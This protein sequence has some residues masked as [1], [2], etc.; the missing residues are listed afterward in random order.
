MPGGPSSQEADG[1]ALSRPGD[2]L[3]SWKAIAAYLGRGITT[4]QRWEQSEGLPV[5]RLPHARGASVFAFK[6]ELDAWKASRAQLMSRPERTTEDL[7]PAL[8]QRRAR[9]GWIGAGL[10]ASA[11]AALVLAGLASW[12]VGGSDEDSSSAVAAP[13]PLANDGGI[14]RSPALSPDGQFVVY[15][16]APAGSTSPGLFI[17]PTAGGEPRRIDLGGLRLPAS[18]RTH[19]SPRGDLIAFLA[20]EAPQ[21]YGLHVMPAM[22]GPP[23][24]ITSMAGIGLCWHPDGRTIG[25]VDRTSVGAPF[26][27]YS[28]D[29]ESGVRRRLTEPAASAFGDTYCALSS[30]GKRLAV[31]RHPTRHASDI[32]V[33]DL[34]A[35]GLVAMSRLTQGMPGMKGIVWS[36]DG[37]WILAGAHGLW[38]IRADG[39]GVRQPVPVA[40]SEGNVWSP[41]VSAGLGGP[42]RLAY[43]FEIFD[44]NIWRWDRGEPGPGTV[45]ELPGSMVWENLAAFSPDGRRIAFASNRTGVNEIWIMEADGSN[46]RQLTSHGPVVVA[47]R[48]SPDGASLVFAAQSADNWEIY[49]IDAD[50]SRSVRLTWEPSQEENPSWSADG[51]W[52]YFRSDRDGPGRIWKMPAGGGPAVRVTSGEGAQALESPDGRTLYFVRADDVPGLWSMPTAGGPETLV[53]PNIRQHMWAVAEGGLAFIARRAI[54]WF[55]VETQ[56]LSVLTELPGGDIQPG[57]SMTRDGR[58]AVWSRTDRLLHDVMIIDDWRP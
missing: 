33:G 27:I 13:R 4:V 44:V 20:Y 40:G 22:G 42:V 32:H 58:T 28:I 25:F 34:P 14:E 23:R 54:N 36:P 55:D 7:P 26:S 6:H 43:A 50:G 41:S 31:V 37:N 53:L 11:A 17:K 5:H 1:T 16:W 9:Q 29:L 18:A 45:R 8:P 38:K 21:M 52:I 30:D 2:Q 46:A 3:D 15:D 35:S 51:Q 19:W 10:A 56:A 57:F 12:R 47:P 24:R 49:R 48:W 39:S